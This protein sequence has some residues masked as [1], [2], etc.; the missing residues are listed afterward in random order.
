MI[1]WM[2]EQELS[3]RRPMPV[4]EAVRFSPGEFP[5]PRCPRC[6]LTLDR[7]Y[8]HFCDRCGQR[9]DWS[10]FADAVLISRS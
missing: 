2:D 5:Y 1:R 4:V 9:L 7:E 6:R 10:G 3:F 8:M